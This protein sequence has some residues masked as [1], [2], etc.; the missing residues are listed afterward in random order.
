MEIYKKLEIWEQE[1]NVRVG[2]DDKV[3]DVTGISKLVFRN[4]NHTIMEMEGTLELI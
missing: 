4:K 2:S 1:K 3:N